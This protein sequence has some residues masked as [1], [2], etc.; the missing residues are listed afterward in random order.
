[1][2]INESVR[3]E[4]IETDSADGTRPGSSSD[5]PGRRPDELS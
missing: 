3:R 5:L 4:Q 2:Q 1:V